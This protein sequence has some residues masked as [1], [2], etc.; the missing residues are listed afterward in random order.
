MVDEE[1]VFGAVNA[2]SSFEASTLILTVIVLAT[3]PSIRKSSTPVTVTVCG[4][5]QF[6]VVNVSELVTVVS[7]LSDETMSI[8]TSVCGCASRT[9]VNV[10]VVPDSATSVEPSVSVT[11]NSGISSSVVVTITV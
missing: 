7:V 10:S 6:E 1:I 9:T 8:T 4:T 2:K 5:F 3:V 11:V